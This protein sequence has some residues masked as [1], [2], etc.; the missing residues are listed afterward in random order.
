MFLFTNF[1]C[2]L[3]SVMSDIDDKPHDGTGIYFY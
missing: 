1:V 3:H 2:D